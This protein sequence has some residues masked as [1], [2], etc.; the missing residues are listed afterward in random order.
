MK[1]ISSF[2]PLVANC[3]KVLILGSMPGE[4]SLQM[5]QYYAH[6]QNSFWYILGEILG[7]D[8]LLSYEQRTH[9]LIQNGICLWDVLKTCVR[10]G[11]L[12]SAIQNTSVISNDF[13][14]FLE[15]RHTIE[16][17]FFNGAKAEQLFRKHVQPTLDIHNLTPNLVRLPS[18]SPAH[19][20]MAKT[21]KL[22][23]WQI[24]KQYL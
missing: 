2:K 19:A 20:A 9:F 23:E 3:P 15:K 7:F 13:S 22:I 5:Q 21:Q 14:S 6:P 8:S 16:Y 18:T 17:I 4:K 12:D 11:S 10:K 1:T 24:I